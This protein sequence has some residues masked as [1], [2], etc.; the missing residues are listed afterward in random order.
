MYLCSIPHLSLAFHSLDIVNWRGICQ[1]VK[2][3]ALRADALD[4]N[5]SHPMFR[6]FVN[7]VIPIFLSLGRAPS[8]HSVNVNEESQ[9]VLPGGLSFLT[10]IE[11]SSDFK[12]TEFSQV[13]TAYVLLLRLVSPWTLVFT[14]TISHVLMRT[15]R[16]AS[17]L[18]EV[19]YQLLVCIPIQ[20]VL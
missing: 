1:K 13:C 3:S 12:I 11:P 20:G 17:K 19:K 7:F 9:T 6:S 8:P 14:W 16:G 15:A 2:R 10:V 5:H 18:Y 4:R